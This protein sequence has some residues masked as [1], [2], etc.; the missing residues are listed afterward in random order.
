[1]P[2]R[3]FFNPSIVC[4]EKERLY[5]LYG[6][7]GGCTAAMAV[8]MI[9]VQ[10]DILSRIDQIKK[11]S[12]I[13]TGS[14]DK[15][16]AASGSYEAHKKIKNSTLKEYEGALHAIHDELDETTEQFMTDIL[17]FIQANL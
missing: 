6:D 2:N 9:N 7:V 14:G 12:L 4:K 11:P 15:I 5:A 16:T 3:Q 1:M 17:D 13:C 10:Q 8:Q